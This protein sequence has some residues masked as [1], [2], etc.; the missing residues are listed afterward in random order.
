MLI[1]TFILGGVGLGRREVRFYSIFDF[2]PSLVG[3]PPEWWRMVVD[4]KQTGF[5]FALTR[6][7]TGSGHS[8]H[9]ISLI[10]RTRRWE[11]LGSSTSLAIENTPL[12]SRKKEKKKSKQIC[13]F[14][15]YKQ[16][17]MASRLGIK[18]RRENRISWT[19]CPKD[20]TALF[21]GWQMAGETMEKLQLQNQIIP[22]YLPFLTFKPSSQNPGEHTGSAWKPG[23]NTRDGAEK[24]FWPAMDGAGTQTWGSFCPRE[25]LSLFFAGKKALELRRSIPA[26]QDPS[27]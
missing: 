17:R 7:S 15:V 13:T 23:K 6:V 1:G 26:K 11:G 5:I 12:K 24:G 14:P 16:H 3:F 9:L 8:I 21:L 18:Y 25:I 20:W 22:R 4:W 19:R 27:D 2:L 10:L